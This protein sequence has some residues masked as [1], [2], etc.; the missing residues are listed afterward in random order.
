MSFKALFRGGV[1]RTLIRPN[2]GLLPRPVQ[3]PR[4]GERCVGGRRVLWFVVGRRTS[5]PTSSFHGDFAPP[6]INA[7]T[8]LSNPW[9]RRAPLGGC[10]GRGK[11]M[12]H[13]EANSM[14]G[15]INNSDL[16]CSFD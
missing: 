4:E 6:D 2:T 7:P 11:R 12:R 3:M 13:V 16:K 15:V 10:D 5:M 8:S 14:R 1:I 9:Q